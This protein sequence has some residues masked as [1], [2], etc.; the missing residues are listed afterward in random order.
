MGDNIADI[1][2]NE[3]ARDERMDGLVRTGDVLMLQEVTK[4][5]VSDLKIE[6]FEKKDI[7]AYIASVAAEAAN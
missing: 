7:L 4:N 2:A 1:V 3:V 5:I 6:G